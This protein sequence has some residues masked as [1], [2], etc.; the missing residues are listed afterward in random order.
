M[1]APWALPYFCL[2][3]ALSS[4]GYLRLLNYPSLYYSFL[5][6]FLTAIIL[7]AARVRYLPS[8]KRTSLLTLDSL[9]SYL[10]LQRP[11]E[12]KLQSAHISK[13]FIVGGW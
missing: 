1:S 4:Y 10:S 13:L 6:V 7:V 3:T 2:D 9:Y 5:V 8:Q 11:W 12:K